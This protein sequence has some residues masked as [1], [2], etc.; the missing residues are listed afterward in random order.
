[1]PEFETGYVIG[2][3]SPLHNGHEHVIRT[4]QQ[5]CSQVVLLSWSLPEFDGCSAEARLRWLETV[6][7][8]CIALV[9]GSKA[10]EKFDFSPPPANDASDQVQ[11]N[12]TSNIIK[13]AGLP[14]PD[15]VFSSEA[16]G[17]GLSQSLQEAFT[18]N[19]SHV[20]VDFDRTQFPISG[21]D[22][23]ADVHT[24]REYL[25]PDVYA[26]FVNSVCFVGAESTGKST[27]S[28]RLAAD[29]K[30][31]R[32]E[33]YGRTLWVERGGEL[34]FE[35]YLHIAETHIEMEEAAKRKANRFIFVDTTP[36]TTLFY[37]KEHTG[38]VDPKL[39]ELSNR[40]YDVT[41]LCHPDFPMVQ[42]GWRGEESFRQAQHEWY[43]KELAA[44]Q[45]D[46]VSL[47]G[48]LEEKIA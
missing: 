20:S 45:I 12:Y 29:M 27:L 41:F 33:E 42:D 16:Y 15:A 18:R 34:D 2:K 8:D 35:D 4:A 5:N 40:R 32:V 28:E 17:L 3:F 30:T 6:F 11:R 10:V 46:F 48:T 25:S 47:L 39:I 43:L 21:T 14:P 1:M 38:R 36:L 7:P 26:S 31:P 44:L 9:I 13:I 24:H 19:V 37:S 22:I 23:R